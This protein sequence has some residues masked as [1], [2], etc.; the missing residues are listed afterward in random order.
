V[1]DKDRGVGRHGIDL[2][3]R[4]HAALG[5]LELRPAADHAHPLGR[6][7]SLSLLAQH[8]QRIRE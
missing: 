2:V 7:G 4:R 3:E 5:E 8:A 1:E 6:R